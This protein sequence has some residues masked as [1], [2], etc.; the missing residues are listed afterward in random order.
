MSADQKYVGTRDLAIRWSAPAG[1]V[2]RAVYLS[3]KLKSTDP[4]RAPREH[5]K[6]G[7]TRFWKVEE[8]PRLDGWWASLHPEL[9]KAPTRVEENDDVKQYTVVPAYMSEYNKEEDMT[10]IHKG[11]PA[12]QETSDPGI[13][14]RPIDP[15]T[16]TF[17]HAGEYP[18]LSESHILAT[19]EHPGLTE[20][21]F[22]PLKDWDH[23]KKHF[24]Q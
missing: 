4:R 13:P 6:E 12:S 20:K 5:H 24:G 16:V 2:S 7:R 21:Y 19:V 8:L 14:P 11:D 23:I 3:F 18:M 10:D 17:T 9:N 15:L 1:A 22:I